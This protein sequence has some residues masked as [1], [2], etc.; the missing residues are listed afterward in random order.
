M[1]ICIS[2]VIHQIRFITDRFQEET[3]LCVT[4][5]QNDYPAK[6]IHVTWSKKPMDDPIHKAAKKAAYIGLDF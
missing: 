3:Y 4:L 2:Q 5:I 1:S 6:F